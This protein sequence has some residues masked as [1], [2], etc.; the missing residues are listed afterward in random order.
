MHRDPLDRA[1]DAIADG[2]P[3]A[4]T[5]IESTHALDDG[6]L[7]GLRLLDDVAAAFRGRA[8]RDASKRAAPLFTWGTL[9]ALELIG[10]G[11]YA[12]VWRAFD[13]WL[14]R[15]VALKLE[16]EPHGGSDR[17]RIT[18]D[19]ARRLARIRH[20]NVLACHGCAV[21][22]GRTGLWTEVVDGRTL[23]AILADDGAFS[24]GEA[25]R[26]GRD[27]ARGLAAI[28][29]AGLVHGDVKAGNVMRERGGRIVLMDFGAGGE[30]R[31]LAE[32][33]IVSATP[34]YLA[35]EVLD[36][37]P[38]SRHGDVHAFGVLVYLLLTGSAPY[39]GTD[40]PAL[41]AAQRAGTRPPLRSACPELGADVA[42]LI[43][44]CLD[45]DPVQRP[46][47]DAV[48]RGLA[49]AAT[50]RDLP[51]RMDRLAKWTV[52]CLAVALAAAVP[53]S[54]WPWLLPA[55]SADAAFVRSGGHGDEPLQGTSTVRD[56]DRLR[57]RVSS[58]RSSHVYVLNE[59]AAGN[60]VVL[61]PLAGDAGA[62][63]AAA[64][65]LPGGAR[66]PALAWEVTPGAGREEFIV[67]AS[68]ERLPALEAALASWPHSAIA[69][70][71]TR[72]LGR[73]VSDE[74]MSLVTGEHLRALLADVPREDP[75]HHV[76]HY[77][78]VH[79]PSR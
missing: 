66:N 79:A 33:R 25:T 10:E 52:R 44:R 58:N 74:P 70:T 75:T 78:F 38:Q 69:A 9:Q 73:V 2:V 71:P 35:P 50:S 57:L 24:V 17:K 14:D 26:V 36:G 34:A 65:T 59:D 31:L 47:A 77:A 56:G 39:T 8:S 62:L 19:E 67:V 76:W 55:W 72:S 13:P 48:A 53:G 1:V 11:A 68:L 28:H 7:A 21:H 16:R 22:E 29:A 20:P 54:A 3:P 45:A 12:Q 40:V 51:R 64:V 41:R 27:V 15:D 4:W 23:A 46:D 6:E 30:E 5:A 18:L 32:R 60:A 37:A 42:A 61:Y 49:A 63:P 43:E